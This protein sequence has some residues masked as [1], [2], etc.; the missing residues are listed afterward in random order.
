MGQESILVMDFM[1]PDEIRL[2][3]ADRTV[4]LPDEVRIQLEVRIPPYGANIHR[5]AADEKYLAILVDNAVEVNVGRGPLK[6]KS[7]LTLHSRW[8]PTATTVPGRLMYLRLTNL[9]DRG[10]HPTRDAIQAMNAGGYDTAITRVCV[11]G[12]T[13]I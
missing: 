3:L 12:V 7:W 11:R 8:V 4:C 13:A 5:I 1:V 9:T 10:D 2:D 6:P